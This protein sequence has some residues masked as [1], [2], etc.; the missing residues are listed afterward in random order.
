MNKITCR[1]GK[2]LIFPYEQLLF[3]VFIPSGLEPSYV[4]LQFTYK[5]SVEANGEDADDIISA[6]M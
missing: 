2:V 1:S 6:L 4:K 5:E 3:V